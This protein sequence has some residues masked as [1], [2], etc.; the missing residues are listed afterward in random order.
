MVELYNLLSIEK[1]QTTAY[2]PEGNGLCERYNRV[3]LDL[4]RKVVEE[5]PCT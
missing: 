3:V 2:H 5:K 1:R 4:L